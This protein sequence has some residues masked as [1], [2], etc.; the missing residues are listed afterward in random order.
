MPKAKS[1]AQLNTQAIGLMKKL[2]MEQGPARVSVLAIK[3]K[4]A[5]QS[6]I[7]TLKVAVAQMEA[8]VTEQRSTRRSTSSKKNSSKGSA[9]TPNQ[10]KDVSQI[11][12]LINNGTITAQGDTTTYS[13]ATGATRRKKASAFIKMYEAKVKAAGLKIAAGEVG[14]A[15]KTPKRTRKPKRLSVTKRYETIK[16]QKKP[17]Y[18][19]KG[20]TIRV[21]GGASGPGVVRAIPKSGVDSFKKLTPDERRA[22]AQFLASDDGKKLRSRGAKRT[23]VV[24]QLIKVNLP[25]SEIRK[26]KKQA[27]KQQPSRQ[28]KKQTAAQI[29]ARYTGLKGYQQIV[30]RAKKQGVSTSGGTMA[31]A[32]RLAKQQ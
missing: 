2:G 23:V 18:I 28:A 13:K 32:K 1:R 24:Q 11:A 26:A 3:N 17:Y 12:K 20:R 6:Q 27:A 5:V 30:K 15:K 10:R 21:G 9:L 14:K 7:A 25:A 29:A 4:A 19:S 22:V 31:I 8:K 16:G